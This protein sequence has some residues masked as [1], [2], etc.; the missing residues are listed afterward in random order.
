MLVLIPES[1]F[2]IKTSRKTK[3]LF[4]FISFVNWICLCVGVATTFE[5]TL[6]ITLA[7]RRSHVLGLMT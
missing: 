4:S 1:D 7:A 3:K 6:L 2:S 5:K